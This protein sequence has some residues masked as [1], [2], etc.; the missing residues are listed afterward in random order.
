MS[1]AFRVG[2][3]SSAAA[4]ARAGE[5][6]KVERREAL[7]AA[8]LDARPEAVTPGNREWPWARR[9]ADRKA[10]LKGFASN[11]WRLP[12][13]HRPRPRGCV[14]LQAAGRRGI[15]RALTR[16]ENDRA[17]LVRQSGAR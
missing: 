10:R 12:P 9:R 3:V 11:P 6:A 7:R 2:G 14:P 4:T 1:R 8:S 13:L 5:V 15:A 16:R 17:C